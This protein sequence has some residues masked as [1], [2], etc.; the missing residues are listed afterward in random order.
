MAQEGTDNYEYGHS[1]EWDSDTADTWSFWIAGFFY[2]HLY[3]GTTTEI[4]TSINPA[5]GGNQDALGGIGLD[6]DVYS[7]DAHHN[8]VY[9]RGGAKYTVSGRDALDRDTK[10]MSFDW[11]GGIGR[12]L[13][14]LGHGAG[15][16]SPMYS[17]SDYRVQGVTGTISAGFLHDPTI[18]AGVAYGTTGTNSPAGERKIMRIVDPF[19]S[20]I[21][22]AYAMPDEGTVGYGPQF[23]RA[24]R[25]QRSTI[26]NL[27]ARR[28]T[29]KDLY[30]SSDGSTW[31]LLTGPASAANLAPTVEPITRGSA[32]A[33]SG[34]PPP[35][36]P[37]T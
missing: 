33:D 13:V 2:Q 11:E 23:V 5:L 17:Y 6:G 34:T 29:G 1:F 28:R 35:V 7:F 26:I 9:P 14:A 25:Q 36:P 3:R 12:R 20:P 32:T 21:L 37:R 10:Y 27:A 15:G 16:G 24:A 19:G 18:A 30:V 8:F 31:T 4:T 22:T